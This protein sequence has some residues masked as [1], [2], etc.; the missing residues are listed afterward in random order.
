MSK[1]FP[2]TLLVAATCLLALS[3]P[4]LA[5][6]NCDREPMTFKLKIKVRD[7]KPIGVTYRGGDAEELLVCLNDQIEWKL[8]DPASAAEFFIDFKSGAPFGGDPNRRAMNGKVLVTI[9]GPDVT[10]GT[11][12]KYDIG[13]VDGGVWDPRI[14]ISEP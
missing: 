11:S 8:I 1:L 3:G 2:L 5:D 6:G 9:G 7:D 4:A 12:Y 13:I 10:P 14:I